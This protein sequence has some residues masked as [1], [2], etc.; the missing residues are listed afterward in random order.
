VAIWRQLVRGVRNLVRRE[1]ADREIV[2]EVAS[3]LE[4]AAASLEDEGLSPEEARRAARRQLGTPT[5]IHEDVRAYGWERAVDAIASDLRYGVRRLLARPG[6]AIAGALTLALGIGASTTIF[7]TVN[8]V[9]FERLPYPDAGRLMMVWD[10]Q[11]GTRLEPTFGTYREIV[12]RSRS[13]EAL[14]VMRPFPPTLTGVAEPE[15]LDGQYVSASYFRVLG[16]TPARGR[17]F[18]AE[19]DVP[20]APFVAV[21]SDSLWRRRFGG[22]ESVV[23]RQ[24]MFDGLPVTVIGVLPPAFENVLSPSAEIWSPLQYDPALPIDGREWGHH[25]RMVGRL[26]PDVRPD[27]AAR[28]LDDISRTDMPAFPRPAWAT[29]QDG[30]ITVPLQDELTRAVRP[31]LL[32]ILGGVALLLGLACVNVTNLL[33]ARGAERRGEL[34]MR[35]AL[36][37]TR[38]RVFRQ[39]LTE[40]LLL[41]VCGG[42]LGIAVAYAAV[43]VVAVLHPPGLPRADAIEIDT[44][45]LLFAVLLT[46]LTGLMT[47][48]APALWGSD[49]RRQSELRRRS[50]RVTSGETM[51][52]RGLVVA[53]VALALVLL[54]GA[55]LLVRSLQSL[56]DVPTG[57]QPSGVL[58]MQVQT[59]GLEFRDASVTDGFF[60]EALDRVREIPGIDGAA[61]ASQLPLTGEEDVWGVHFETVPEGAAEQ[62]RDAHRYAVSAGYLE[63]MG[64]PLLAGRTLNAGDV[65]GTLPVAVLSESMARRRMPGLDPIGR[66]FRIGPSESGPWFTIVG[67]VADVTQTSLA[68]S[69]TDAIYVPATQWSEGRFAD[70]A[71]WLVVRSDRETADLTSSVR[72]AIRSVDG[73][74]SILRVAAMD[75]R[76]R[77]SE[78]DRRFAL[79]VF[80]AFGVVALILA[81]LG[82]YSL[83]SSSVTER[84]REIGVRAALGASRRRVLGL[85]LRQGMV[86]AAL[87]ILIGLAGSVAASRALETLL[88]GV[89]RLDL[90]THLAVAGLLA[91][92]AAAACGLP[93]WR[94]AQVP[95]SIAL[96]AE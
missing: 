20:G 26:R 88:F 8:P 64:I 75:E 57:F 83:L 59:A 2:D 81:A 96:R 15:R 49:R 32:A 48:L 53:Q 51:A 12:E 71:R 84:T 16:V 3:Y 77:A 92:V 9:L 58:T 44:G 34:A 67:V 5:A 93:A 61:F 74:Q 18:R 11:G 68:V 36:G 1:A 25:L 95:P 13:F 22:D 39:L 30:F 14:A 73:N 50:A 27:Q 82:T 78:A 47:G 21:I 17:D 70:N 46:T 4:Q 24:V 43:D 7:S 90:P 23:G 69:A 6:T 52:R 28:E 33:L 76:L 60:D 54:A 66:R 45:V 38:A 79:F 29:L 72:E 89:S 56:F 41:A 55:G 65:S 19:E 86:L 87:G 85:V 62:S 42:A 35:A 94:A 80:E 40:G 10:G 63:G 31:A 91:I 37:A